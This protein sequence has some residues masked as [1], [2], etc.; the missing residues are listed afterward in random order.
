MLGQQHSTL[1]PTAGL[2]LKLSRVGPGQSLDERPDDAGSSVGGP[3]RGTFS[4]G[5]FKK[6]SQCPRA[7][8]GDIAL[9]RVQTLGWDIKCMS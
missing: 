9:C 4:F 8:I 2:P 7:V 3:V 5:L 1:H 6:K